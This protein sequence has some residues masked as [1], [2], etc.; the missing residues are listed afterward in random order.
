MRKAKA[1]KVTSTY[2]EDLALL[3]NRPEFKVF[4]KLMEI[5]EHNIIVRSFKIT[6][7]DPD[8]RIKKAQLEGRIAELR[9]FKK[10]FED[11]IK[12]NEE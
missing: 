7:A 11:A 5:E 1:I 12:S 4:Q 6:A 9:M 8:L 2:K 10:T 3:A